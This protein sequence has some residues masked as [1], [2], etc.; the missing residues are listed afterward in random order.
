VG[1]SIPIHDEIIIS[2]ARMNKVIT[3]DK[4]YGILMC[5]AGCLLGDLHDHLRDFGHIVPLEI[6]PKYHCMIGGNLSTNAGGIHY[7]KYNSL[8]ANT[9]GLK[10]VLPNGTILDNMSN[11]RK[12]NTGYD[13]KHLFIGAEGTLGIITECAILCP[14]LPKKSQVCI[15]GCK[16][17]EHVLELLQEAKMKLSDVITAVE[18]MDQQAVENV[19]S[20]YKVT[21]PLPETYPFYA[22][23]EIGSTSDGDEDT[24]RLSDFIEQNQDL[25]M[26]LSSSA[27]FLGRHSLS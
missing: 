5:E 1:G 25:I 21:N 22:M 23:M 13:L 16:S 10:A 20:L 9:I 18:F 3:F 2:L 8:H 15:I 11:L 17:F 27:L 12:D 24:V 7:M 4:S 26:V 14:S 19:F 6:G